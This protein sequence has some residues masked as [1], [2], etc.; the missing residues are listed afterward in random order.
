MHIPCA[1][2][3]PPPLGAST[4][5]IIESKVD[6]PTPLSPTRA[7][8]SPRVTWAENGANKTCTPNDFVSCSIWISDIRKMLRNETGRGKE[9]RGLSLTRNQPSVLSLQPSAKK[10][11][12]G[13]PLTAKRS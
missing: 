7:I 2:W 13:V 11:S 3:I 8:R 12:R 5:A 1:R 6:F 9:V 4:P 10:I